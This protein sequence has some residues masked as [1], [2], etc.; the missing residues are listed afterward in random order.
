MESYETFLE[1]HFK[2]DLHLT[3]PVKDE[4]VSKGLRRQSEG[5]YIQGSDGR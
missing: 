1:P 2:V 4:S 3:K 5:N